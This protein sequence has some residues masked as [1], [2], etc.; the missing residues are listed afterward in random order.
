MQCE[1][2]DGQLAYG[3]IGERWT[4]PLETGSSGECAT[5][6]AVQDDI[7][8]F[9][10]AAG[11]GFVWRLGF[12]SSAPGPNLFSTNLGP[13]FLGG[14]TQALLAENSAVDLQVV[15]A[16]GGFVAATCSP[17]SEPEW[18]R[19]NGELAVAG[20][21]T[22]VA[23]DAPC[24][25]YAPSIVWTG[26]G[27][28]TS[29]TDSRG[30][31]VASLDEQGTLVGEEVL[32]EQIFE[33]PLTRFSKN[34]DRVLFVFNQ[35]SVG[36][37]GRGFYGVLDLQGTPLGEVQPIGKEDSNLRYVAIAPSGD[38][39]LVASDSWVTNENGTLLTTIAGDGAALRADRSFSGHVMFLGLT[40][41]AY[42]GSLLIAQ[43]DTGGQFGVLEKQIALIDDAGEVAY[44]EAANLDDS[45][46]WPLG[47]V[48]DPLRDLVIERPVGDDAVG[49]MTVQEYGCLE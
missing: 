40:P 6:G 39:W 46:F 11:Y 18:I 30:L 42:G 19:L 34:G 1:T 16:L 25:A 43:V 17:E 49:V 27:Y 47:A 7:F 5:C 24:G 35:G 10:S 13:T 28:L 26:E 33:S 15:P 21:P 12:D 45:G 14:A 31:V 22:P 20:A 8:G 44:S 32:S 3:P 38:G 9:R 2:V 4:L 37:G 29:F 36:S 48:I 41:S 23:P